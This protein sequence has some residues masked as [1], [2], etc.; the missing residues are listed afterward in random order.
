MLT[1]GPESGILEQILGIESGSTTPHSQAE[2]RTYH[3]RIQV[4][5]SLVQ[6]TAGG[7]PPLQVPGVPEFTVPLSV[8][9]HRVGLVPLEQCV[10]AA[11][12]QQ[13]HPG[14]I[15]LSTSPE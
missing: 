6:S 9:S 14:V 5:S 3:L 2:E 13:S 15:I 12:S 7:E 10:Q 4:P 11:Q 1:P 8:N